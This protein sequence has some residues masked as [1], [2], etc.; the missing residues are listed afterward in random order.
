MGEFETFYDISKAKKMVGFQ[1]KHNWR[2]EM[3]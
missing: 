2:S 3:G 1:P